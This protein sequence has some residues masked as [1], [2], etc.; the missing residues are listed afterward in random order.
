M[1]QLS[2]RVT[3]PE[4]TP[5]I[6]GV[7]QINDRRTDPADGL[8]SLAL[9]IAAARAA[10]A[11]AGLA[12]LTDIDSLGVVAQISCRYDAALDGPV[13]AALGATPAHSEVSRLPF[14]DTP[15]R[16]L[17]EAANRIGAGECRLALVTGG[18]A[19]RTATAR[20][21]AAAVD[22]PVQAISK[23]RALGYAEAF[24]LVAPT[25][26]YP[27]YENATRAA[28]GQTLAEGQAET[29]ALWAAMS[30]VAA[31]NPAAWI[32]E[33]HSPADILA[34]TPANR[35]IAFPY[36]KL[37]VTN[38]AVNQ[39]AAFLVASVAE[40]RRRGIPDARM[41][42][43]GMGAAAREAWTILPRARYDRSASMATVLAEVLAR[44]QL[45]SAAELDHLELYSCFPCI[46]KMARRLL[47]WPT[48]R[49][50]TVTG[51]MTFAGG[52]FAN[53]MSH[54]IAAMAMRLRGTGERG[55]VYANGG[56][57][58]DNHAILLGGA[59]LPHAHFP[60]DFDVQGQAD[61]ARDPVPPLDE[62]YAGPATIETYTLF[63]DRDGAPRGGVVVA[64][65]PAGDRTCA[66]VDGGDAALVAF[67]TDGA[68]EPVGAI[69]RIELGDD[70]LRFWHA[71]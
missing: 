61:A 7:G 26:I 53:Y 10:A 54:V 41:V 55:L 9:M 49:A 48:D 18:E 68:V 50:T 14:G 25:D 51:G 13:A 17:N 8:D 1:I 35:Q 20:T 62:D 4:H 71:H 16:M 38:G 40:A 22:S 11:D 57:A 27:L 30:E 42:H 45:T 3:D 37:M 39:G 43:I 5:V 52:P 12:D 33:P 28:W 19:L 2:G 31:T 34:D 56:F 65:T 66:H 69:G 36:R 15:V 6:I 70:D 60:H 59:P 46:P 58:T 21:R 29:A 23:Q 32:R 47:D 64:R 24:G 63:Y 67:L 44:N